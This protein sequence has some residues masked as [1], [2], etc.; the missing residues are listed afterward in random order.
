MG[1]W[2]LW[3]TSCKPVC[4]ACLSGALQSVKQKAQNGQLTAF[5]LAHTP[6]NLLNPKPCPKHRT[7]S[8]F[9]KTEEGCCGD[10]CLGMTTPPSYPMFRPRPYTVLGCRYVEQGVSK[11]EVRV[12]TSGKEGSNQKGNYL[13]ATSGDK[14]LEQHQG[15][16]PRITDLTLRVQ[17]PNNHIL[18]QNLY[19]NYYYPNP[20]Y[21]IIGYMD[22][23]GHSK[24]A[25][26]ETWT[27]PRGYCQENQEPFACILK[28]AALIPGSHKPKT[29]PP[30]G[31][32]TQIMGF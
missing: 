29:T 32:R 3:G 31:P 23:L 1:S 4:G 19:Q 13:K 28:L 14:P 18:T 11:W 21:L 12:R 24:G 5:A 7:S 27:L 25:N 17:V 26:A 20:K 30:K 8:P 2:T 22:P 6:L 10:S 16:Q 9:N 15:E